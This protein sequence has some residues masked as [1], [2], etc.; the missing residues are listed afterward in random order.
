MRLFI[1]ILLA[2]LPSTALGQAAKPTDCGAGRTKPREVAACLSPVV[3]L[4]HEIM[5]T[6]VRTARR[7]VGDLAREALE[8]DQAAFLDMVDDGF[9]RAI[10]KE[11]GPSDGV[12]VRLVASNDRR[13]EHLAQA[14]SE[15]A[16][17]L[18]RIGA[19]VEGFGGHWA[20]YKARLDLTPVTSGVWSAEFEVLRYGASECRFQTQVRRADEPNAVVEVEPAGRGAKSA[21][22]DAKPSLLMTLE[23]SALAVVAS[24]E[25][26]DDCRSQAGQRLVLFKTFGP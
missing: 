19:A 18:G 8:A 5:E 25:A 7:R 3:A 11:S 14:I 13:I 12:V 17:W 20:N 9:R 1:V 10:A 22:G 24:G 15:R 16:N 6:A 26:S 4:A 21:G 23:R 2:L